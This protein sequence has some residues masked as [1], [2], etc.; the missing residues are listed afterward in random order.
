MSTHSVD[1]V[2]IAEI[3]KHPNADSLGLVRVFGYTCA[4]RLGDFHPGDLVAYTPEREADNFGRVQLKI[5]GNGYLE[6]A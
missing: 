3:A 4:V 6:R 1:V 5:V 2:R